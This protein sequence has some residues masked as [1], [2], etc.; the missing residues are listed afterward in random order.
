MA[1]VC[2]LLPS[3]Q[4]ISRQNVDLLDCDSSL[5]NTPH[6]TSLLRHWIIWRNFGVFDHFHSQKQVL[7]WP[8]VRYEATTN[9]LGWPRSASRWW[10]FLWTPGHKPKVWWRRG[11]WRQ[12]IS[13]KI[14]DENS[15]GR[16]ICQKLNTLIVIILFSFMQPISPWPPSFFGGAHLLL[17]T[18]RTIPVDFNFCASDDDNKTNFFAPFI[19]MEA[20]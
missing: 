10:S 11:T 12:R 5:I 17:L 2:V 14:D 8:R 4:L 19:S 20:V 6:W 16:H 13:A 7:E 1:C 9:R 18:H 15:F 3:K